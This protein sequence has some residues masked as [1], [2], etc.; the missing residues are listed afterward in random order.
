MTLFMILQIIAAIGA[1]LTAGIFYAFS[2][3]V[4]AG[5]GRIPPE[6]GIAAMNSINVTV[7]N[8]WFMA[9]FMGT[10][11]LCAIL[12]VMALFK[13]SE[14]ASFLIIA[15]SAIYIVGSFFVTVIFNVP[16]NNALAAAAPASSEGAAL[17]ARYLVEWTWW[18]H[19]RTAAPLVAM[20]LIIIGLVVQSRSLPTS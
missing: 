14:P 8:P 9:V 20:A 13:W 18:N 5:L 12:I 6:Q 10:P 19:V 2:T 15:A 4:M 17:W 7:I 11:A 1:G 16:L 3:F